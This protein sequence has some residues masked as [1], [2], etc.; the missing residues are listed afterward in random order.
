MSISSNAVLHFTS[1]LGN[2]E[3]ILSNGFKL[4]Y[5]KEKNNVRGGLISA[6]VPMVSF[7]DIP[8]SEIKNHISN[9]GSYGIG[10]KKEWAVKNCLNPVL[11]LECN[12]FL[13]ENLRL[14]IIHY[15]NPSSGSRTEEQKRLVDTARYI[16][17]Y[18]RDLTREGK[19]IKDYRFYD[20]REWRYVPNIDQVGLPL[21]IK[22]SISIEKMGQYNDIAARIF[23]KFKPTDISYIILKSEDEISNF[24]WYLRQT[25]KRS[26]MEDVDTLITRII[27]VNQIYSDF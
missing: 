13:G 5:C 1:S 14:A 7:C 2:L 26:P 10:L 27:T 23:L 6:Y 21:I 15:Y 16:K 17:N 19:T 22:G 11:Y 24:I 20:E 4:K 8:F 9:Y 3:G 18:Q 25:F 12:S